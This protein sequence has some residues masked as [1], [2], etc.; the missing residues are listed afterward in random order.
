[1]GDAMCDKDEVCKGCYYEERSYSV[2]P[3][4]DCTRARSG[5]QKDWFAPTATKVSAKEEEEI[6][7]A[8]FGPRVGNEDYLTKLIDDHWAYIS[9]LLTS[10]GTDKDTVEVAEFH[11]KSAFRHGWK[12]AHEYLEEIHG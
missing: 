1:M 3:C 5:M 11:Y 12:H 4:N 10:H 2:A 7:R 8:V 9:A 6:Q